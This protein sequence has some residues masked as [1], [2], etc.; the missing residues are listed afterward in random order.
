MSRIEQS[1]VPRYNGS[2]LMR[3]PGSAVAE[4]GH[5]NTPQSASRWKRRLWWAVIASMAAL[6]TI[7]V[8]I[9]ALEAPEGSQLRYSL[10]GLLGGITGVALGVLVSFAFWLAG[11]LRV[12]NLLTT[13]PGTPVA[14][15]AGLAEDGNDVLAQLGASYSFPKPSHALV[16][17]GATS[18]GLHVYRRF[19]HSII[20]VPANRIC[21]IR[22]EHRTLASGPEREVM[23]FTISDENG[24]L[25]HLNLTIFCAA[26]LFVI[27]YSRKYLRDLLNRFRE[28]LE[29]KD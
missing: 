10:F 11:R 19:G 2:N 4:S 23:S 5:A 16:S 27:P 21:D 9:G 15:V 3:A 12:R 8:F 13:S 22:F 24:R 1:K 29:V 14:Y 20:F 6:S 18:K 7:R 17:F 26:K 25:H 28:T